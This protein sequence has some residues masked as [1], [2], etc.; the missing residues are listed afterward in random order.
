MAEEAKRAICRYEI[1]EEFKKVAE[2]MNRNEYGLIQITRKFPGCEGLK[3]EEVRSIADKSFEGIEGAFIKISIS[4]KSNIDL[5]LIQI[6]TV[7]DSWS[8]K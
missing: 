4:S 8:G 1:V 5:P 2:M 6:S 3:N 7:W